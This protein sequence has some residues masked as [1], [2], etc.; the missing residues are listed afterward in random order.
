MINFIALK[1]RWKNEVK[2][3]SFKIAHC[4]NCQLDFFQT[5]SFIRLCPACYD[6]MDFFR[7][8]A[9]K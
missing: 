7:T 4:P 3:S 5:S 9:P 1:F 8:I 6:D 2:S